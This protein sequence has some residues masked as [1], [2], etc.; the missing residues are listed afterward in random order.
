MYLSFSVWLSSIYIYPCWSKWQDFTFYGCGIFHC[1]CIYL[2]IYTHTHIPYL[3]LFFHWWLLRLLLYLD[4]LNK[5][6][7]WMHISFW[8]SVFISFGWRYR[9]G[10]ARSYGS[11]TVIFCTAPVNIPNEHAC[12]WGFPFPHIL[13]NTCYLSFCT[14]PVLSCILAT[15]I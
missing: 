13:T 3:Y 1:M 6:N 10:I 4:Y 14:Q 15:S 2:Y 8:I 9:S 7:K 5:T 12:A 11:C